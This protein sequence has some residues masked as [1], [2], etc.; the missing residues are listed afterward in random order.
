MK[1]FVSIIIRTMNEKEYLSELLTAIKNQ[2]YKGKYELII[3][4]NESSDGTVEL[5][6]QNYARVVT[7]KKEEFSFPCSLNRGAESA[8]GEILVFLVGHAL[9]FK[10]DWLRSGLSHFSDP[11]VAGVYSP[12]I[13]KKVYLSRTLFLLAQLPY[14]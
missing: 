5:A 10:H 2:G 11:I 9:P 14:R 4:D 13:P 6:T 3:V 8:S 12:V 1:P 7:I